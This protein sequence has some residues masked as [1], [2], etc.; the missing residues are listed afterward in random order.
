MLPTLNRLSLTAIE[1]KT[2]MEAWSLKG[3][4]DYDSL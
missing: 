3:V 4:T 2:P 1:G